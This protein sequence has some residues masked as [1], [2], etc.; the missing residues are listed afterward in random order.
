M[1]LG[2]DELAADRTLVGR[3]LCEAY[4]DRADAFLADLFAGGDRPRHRHQPRRP[5]AATA[6]AS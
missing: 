3:A 2:R 6:G 1:D 4:A 5:R